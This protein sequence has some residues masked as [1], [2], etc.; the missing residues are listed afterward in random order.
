MGLTGDQQP[1]TTDFTDGRIPV[2][3]PAPVF[4]AGSWAAR[5][6]KNGVGP[7]TVRVALYSHDTMGLGHARRNL[8]LAQALSGSDRQV[9]ILLITGNRETSAFQM[10][11][12]ADCLTIPS[13]HK[14]SDGSYR[15]RRLDMSLQELIVMRGNLIRTALESFQPD[16]FIV[17][18]VPRGA[19]RELDPALQALRQ[20]GQTQC[21]LGLRDILDAPAIVDREWSK[22]GNYSAI[23]RYFDQI[24]VFGDPA[25]YDPVVEYGF[26]SDIAAKVRYTGYLDQCARLNLDEATGRDL[27]AGLNL[28]DG[29]LALCMVGGGQ[30]G[31]RVAEA[32]AQADL[33]SGTNGVVLT[34]PFMPEETQRRLR[35]YAVSNP[36]LRILDFV[37]EPGFLMQ[38]ADSV[39]AMGGYNTVCEVLSY[40]KR[41][42]IVPRVRP[43]EEQHI[44]AR[45][46]SE[47]GK[48]DM[49]HPD[50]LSPARLSA[51]LADERTG[52][53]N[54]VTIDRNGLER[55]PQL[56]D[57]LLTP[58]AAWSNG[59]VCNEESQY[60]AL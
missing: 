19:V 18:N 3:G 48:L 13:I 6:P 20:S 4:D 17:D 54:D 21:V 60:A 40:N 47:L 2:L 28:P 33:P 50:C 1:P 16:V 27:L 38:R 42:L 11:P 15:A 24:W 59:Q 43:R 29:K 34:G 5:L 26:P 46:L 25:V 23:R 9:D 35:G 31:S 56:L 44:R 8:S 57:E 39:V 55:L 36:R 52:P 37:Q 49:L 41:A 30:D 32:F 10:P 58:A 51:W 7:S 22:A 45:R 14:A 53:G 12:G